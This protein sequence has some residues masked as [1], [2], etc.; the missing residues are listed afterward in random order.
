MPHALAHANANT[1]LLTRHSI[2]AYPV[3]SEVCVDPDLVKRVSGIDRLGNLSSRTVSVSM[4][5]I[6][7]AVES[8]SNISLGTLS[9]ATI[10][11]LGSDLRR[12]ITTRQ[13]LAIA[14][15]PA[16][17]VAALQQFFG[18][19]TACN[20]GLETGEWVLQPLS[21]SFL[22]RDLSIFKGRQADYAGH[23]SSIDGSKPHVIVGVNPSAWLRTWAK[24][25]EHQ[26][27]FISRAFLG[28]DSS[29]ISL[30]NYRALTELDAKIIPS[31]LAYRAFFSPK[32]WAYVVVFVY[33]SLR[34]LP[35]AF[36]KGFHGSV[37]FLW[38]MDIVTAIPYTWGLVAFFTG[39]R[40]WLR[41]TGLSVTI[42]TFIA[43][44]IYFWSHGRG[45]SWWVNL[46]VGCMIVGA[47]LYEGV[48]YLRD[49][50]IAK[51]LRG[52]A[53]RAVGPGNGSN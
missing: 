5:I 26:K 41:L 39:R 29:R 28:V 34:A 20:V 35:V 44:Y 49:R 27:A 21:E 47:I 24:G 13:H 2:L 53:A 11:A 6:R 9:Q 25:S 12:F 1:D 22:P 37:A 40:M 14:L 42:I 51:G 48:N 52:A 36:V 4:E 17:S 8:A 16:Q 10:D 45:Y 23:S 15:V 38:G 30:R 50:A 33:S 31:S 19:N 43:P 7:F 32:V 18:K 46:V 3:L